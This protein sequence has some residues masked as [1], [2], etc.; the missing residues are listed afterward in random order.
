MPTVAQ[1]DTDLAADPNLQFVGPYVPGDAGTEVVRV[2]Y[3]MYVPPS[4]V[5]LFI[6][7]ALTPREAYDRLTGVLI[8]QGHMAMGAPLVKW[9][10]V[11]LTRSAA[12]QPSHLARPDV[13]ALLADNIL[14][15]HQADILQWDLTGLHSP[16]VTA[17]GAAQISGAISNLVADNRLARQD[18]AAR[19]AREAMKTPEMYYGPA[20]ITITNLLR[21]CHVDR[22]SLLPR[23]HQDLAQAPKKKDRT[24]IQNAVDDYNASIGRCQQLLITP[25]VAK[26]VTNIEY[27]MTNRDDLTTGIHPFIVG[28][29]TPDEQAAQQE[30]IDAYKVIHG[31]AGAPTLSDAQFLSSPENVRLPLSVSQGRYNL[32]HFQALIGAMLGPAHSATINIIDL[33]N[34]YSDHE[35]ELETMEPPA[36]VPRHHV[37]AVIIRCI[38]LSFTWWVE[39]QWWSNAPI[40]C[41][42][43]CEI[44]ERIF[45]GQPWVPTFPSGY[46]TVPPAP[47]P[48]TMPPTAPP[49][50]PAPAPGPPAPTPGS[51][52]ERLMNPQCDAAFD[53][54]KA[55]PGVQAR[56]LYKKYG[57]ADNNTLPKCQADGREMCLSY[58]VKG[59]C[60]TSCHRGYDHNPQD[61]EDKP[62]LLSFCQACWK[63]E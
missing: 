4:L 49:A 35:Q 16:A 15:Q 48:P 1:A 39:R 10:R 19:R 13:T 24:V 28:Y 32:Q 59:M 27:R 26:K 47:T 33:L 43:F 63:T 8:A 58:H 53:Q 56:D 44:F 7:E 29:R 38:Q 62:V 30:I 41:P 34:M 50:A 22:A 31:D 18:D 55:V 5:G 12:G 57:A 40:P 52:G 23:V 42:N 54:Y 20:A 9:L 45:T 60:N 3:T 61:P 46:L 11:A 14:M 51:G 36:N 37:P 25:S 21:L 6:D 17:H 2:R